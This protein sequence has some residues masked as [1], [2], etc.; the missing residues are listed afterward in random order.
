VNTAVHQAEVTPPLYYVLLHLWITVTG[1]GS[2]FMLRLPSALAGIALVGA[3]MWFGRV[4]ADIR[5]GLIAGILTALSPLVL[6]YAQE[7]RAYVFVMLAVTIAAAATIKAVQEPDKRR[8]LTLAVGST[9]L[10]VLLHYTAVL[11]LFPVFLWAVRQKEL[12]VKGRLA[13]GAAVAVPFVALIPLMLVQVGAGHHN[14]A[15][16]AY[17]KITPVGLLKLAGTP[18]DGR[19]LGGMSITYELGFLVLVDALALLAFGD[20]FRRVRGRWLLVAASVLPILLI[21]GVSALKHPMALT[22]YAAVAVP[23]MLVAI[24][25]V[26]SRLPQAMGVALMAVAVVASVIGIVAAQLPSGQWPD[27][28]GAFADTAHRWRS[29]DV[30]V[31]LNNFAYPDSMDFYADRLPA[32]AGGAKGYYTSYDAFNAPQ[33]KRALKDCKRVFVVSSPPANPEDVYGMAAQNRARVIGE[34]QWGGAYPV[35]VNTV[36]CNR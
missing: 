5:A 14:I 7:I 11:V 3:V 34:R 13:L 31:G 12:S 33:V 6:Q 20:V 9:A 21:V 24:G 23:F 10:A 26:I 29:G 25:V 30:V 2:E 22:R 19:A 1:A 35:Q 17:A 36:S 27:A 8:W 32:G 18:W 15:A 28:R 4:V 16:D